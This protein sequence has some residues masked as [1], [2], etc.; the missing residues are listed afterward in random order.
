VV[1]G[2]LGKLKQSIVETKQT[3]EATSEGVRRLRPPAAMIHLGRFNPH[4]P[5][6]PSF[7]S[8][9][10]ATKS[11]LTRAPPWRIQEAIKP[12]HTALVSGFEQMPLSK[13][14]AFQETQAISLAGR[15]R[16]SSLF[17]FVNSP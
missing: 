11:A 3:K 5:S 9:T 8:V 2:W 7:A 13:F 17:G 6:F 14:S 1:L 12:F 10:P 15:L 4:A 16:G